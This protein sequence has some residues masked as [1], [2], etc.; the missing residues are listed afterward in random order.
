MALSLDSSRHSENPWPMKKWIGIIGLALLGLVLGAGGALALLVNAS[1]VGG[2]S[3]G[4]WRGNA[5]TGA[6]AADPLTRAVV[7][8][9][10][11][12]ALNKQETVYYS[13]NTDEA[14]A[15]LREACVYELSGAPPAARW[16][17][18]TIYA[19]D[20]FL[21]INSDDAFS[22]DATRMVMGLDGRF[23]ARIS[24][25]Q[26]NAANWI[27]SRKAGQ[28]D[29]TIRLYNPDPMIQADLTKA[30]LPQVTLVSC[31]GGAS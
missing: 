3:V 26:D 17:S 1:G 24:P 21:P 27:S 2:V 18:V 22:M 23:S 11:L 12:L 14:G 4:Q 28:F 19:A 15:R 9:V 13:R 20:N 29:L 31:A 6:P 10:G 16:W 25:T 8:R 30:D 5:L 7:A